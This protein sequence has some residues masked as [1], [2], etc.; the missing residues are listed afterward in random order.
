MATEKWKKDNIDKMRE[1]RRTHYQS[2]KEQY[3]RRNQEKKDRLKLIILDRKKCGCKYCPENNPVCLDFHHITNNKE[4]NIAKMI[5]K[6]SLSKLL[7]ELDKCKVVCSNCH[8]KIH[9]GVINT[10]QHNG[11][12]QV[13]KTSEG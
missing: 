13:S 12:H 5:N 10:S 3:Y 1:Y 11:M 8:R 9:A 7:I 4:Y 2:N 6:G